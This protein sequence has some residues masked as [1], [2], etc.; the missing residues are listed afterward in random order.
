MNLALLEDFVKNP[1]T[2]FQENFNK[3]SVTNFGRMDGE[4]EGQTDGGTDGRREGRTDG[5][6]VPIL[7][8]FYSAES[9]K[10]A[11]PNTRS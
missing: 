9:P 11:A 3:F 7:L 5:H 10:S 4:T 2:E 1:S 8:L 6:A